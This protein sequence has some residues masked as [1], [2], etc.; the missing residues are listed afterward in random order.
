MVSFAGAILLLLLFLLWLTIFAGLCRVLCI[1]LLLLLYISAIE[2]V[3]YCHS[4]CIFAFAFVVIQNTYQKGVWG[5]RKQKQQHWQQQIN[6]IDII[7]IQ[8]TQPLWF[9]LF[10]VHDT[11]F[12]FPFP[13][14][15]FGVIWFIWF[16]L[17]LTIIN[18][19]HFLSIWLNKPK[20]YAQKKRITFVRC[21]YFFYTN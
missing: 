12:P 3:F 1:I 13:L 19:V 11:L 7:K 14:A 18:A 8:F 9:F 10:A 16:I 6:A 5:Q 4:I 17:F 20:K 15:F 21:C 2:I